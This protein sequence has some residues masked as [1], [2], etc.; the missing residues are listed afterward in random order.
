[1]QRAQAAMPQGQ[2]MVRTSHVEMAG[3][4]TDPKAAV[5]NAGVGAGVGAG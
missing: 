2:L 5:L 3:P 1:M 4:G